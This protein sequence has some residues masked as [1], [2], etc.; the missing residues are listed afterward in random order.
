MTTVPLFLKKWDV[1]SLYNGWEGPSRGNEI[2]PKCIVFEVV[3]LCKFT[4]PYFIYDILHEIHQRERVQIKYKITEGNF[5]IYE[6]LFIAI[7]LQCC[8]CYTALTG[9]V[10]SIEMLTCLH[11]LWYHKR[12]AHT[13]KS[14]FVSTVYLS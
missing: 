13:G 14:R 8:T 7:F 4:F 11:K 5:F 12:N 2:L 1:L 10:C 6:T 9:V 3:F